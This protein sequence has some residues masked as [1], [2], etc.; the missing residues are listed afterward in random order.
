MRETSGM[1]DGGGGIATTNTTGYLMN[2][3]NNRSNNQNAIDGIEETDNIGSA[4]EFIKGFD[5]FFCF[6]NI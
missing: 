1:D 2:Q 6:K 3:F 4:S 5:F